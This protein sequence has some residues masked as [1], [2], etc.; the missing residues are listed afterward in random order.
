MAIDG[1]KQLALETCTYLTSELRTPLYSVLQMHS[2]TPTAQLTKLY[3]TVNATPPS[4]IA[5]TN[6]SVPRGSSWRESIYNIK[7]PDI[8]ISVSVRPLLS[9]HFA[10]WVVSVM[11]VQYTCKCHQGHIAPVAIVAAYGG[12]ISPWCHWLRGVACVTMHILNQLPN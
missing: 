1:P 5:S 6:K 8:K 11:Q 9:L 12:S 3:T 7:A 2:P 4:A 10:V